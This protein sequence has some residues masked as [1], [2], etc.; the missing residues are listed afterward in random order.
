[1]ACPGD[2]HFGLEEEINAVCMEKPSQDV[3]VSRFIGELKLVGCR[4]EAISAKTVYPLSPSRVSVSPKQKDCSWADVKV[5]FTESENSRLK[6]VGEV[7]FLV[8]VS[9]IRR[10]DANYLNS[11]LVSS[12]IKPRVELKSFY[13]KTVSEWVGRL[14]SCGFPWLEKNH[15]NRGAGLFGY[16]QRVEVL[17]LGME[18]S[19]V[20]GLYL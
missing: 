19:V 9:Q 10:E 14:Y 2:N 12:F 11:N 4:N 16:L 1:M 20:V 3:Y 6:V 17:A 13:K 5:V 7:E 8:A 18:M 15:L